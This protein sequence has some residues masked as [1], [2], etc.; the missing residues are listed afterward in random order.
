MNLVASVMYVLSQYMI[1]IMI[2]LMVEANDILCTVGRC[3]ADRRCS[4]ISSSFRRLTA[5]SVE[6]TDVPTNSL[7][8][9]HLEQMPVYCLYWL[10]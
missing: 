6:T 3:I 2:K 5:S 4:F 8:L 9:P 1:N 10:V 7:W